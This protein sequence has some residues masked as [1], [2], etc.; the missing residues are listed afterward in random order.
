M[1]IETRKVDTWSKLSIFTYQRVNILFL[2]FSSIHS[3][4]NPPTQKDN[5][6]HTCINY[7]SMASWSTLNWLH[8]WHK[9]S[10][11]IIVEF[12]LLRLREGKKPNKR[13][14]QWYLAQN[15][16]VNLNT[17]WFLEATKSQEDAS[18]PL[19]FTP[20]VGRESLSWIKFLYGRMNHSFA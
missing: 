13:H 7:K 16:A 18:Q 8:Q 3:H 4:T 10:Q 17:N 20:R 11:P 19:D 5:A 6:T 12:D 1:I 15:F 9:L 2:T 14:I